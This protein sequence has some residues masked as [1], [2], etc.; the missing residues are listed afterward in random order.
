M[1]SNGFEYDS[2]SEERGGS[3]YDSPLG[4]QSMR[5]LRGKIIRRAFMAPVTTGISEAYVSME[6]IF[7]LLLNPFDWKRTLAGILLYSTTLPLKTS[8]L[9][10]PVT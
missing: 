2:G 10:A 1:V 9:I 8:C 5:L 7:A 3:M 4:V 6:N